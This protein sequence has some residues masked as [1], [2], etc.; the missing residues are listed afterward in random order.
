M[1]TVPYLYLVLCL[2]STLPGHRGRGMASQHLKWATQVADQRALPIW[3]DASPMSVS[4]YKRFGFFTVG[5]VTSDLS[6]GSKGAGIYTHTC[7]L[8]EPKSESTSTQ[9]QPSDVP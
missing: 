3:L 7:M 5:E 8:R 4:L 1:L 9:C 6:I 2:I